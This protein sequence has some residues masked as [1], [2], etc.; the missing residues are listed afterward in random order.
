MITA[1][2][3][4]R[5]TDPEFEKL[6]IEGI[7]RRGGLASL[8]R[9]IQMSG[10]ARKAAREGIRRSRPDLDPEG[11]DLLFLEVQYGDQFSEADRL[12]I[13]R[14]RRSKGFYD[15]ASNVSAC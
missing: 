6:W 12:E 14:L 1:R 11:Q 10:E 13:V 9:C 5:D 8:S 7:R 3:L 15:G 4:S 2:P